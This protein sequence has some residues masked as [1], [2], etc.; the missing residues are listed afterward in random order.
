MKKSKKYTLY[1]WILLGLWFLIAF[2]MMYYLKKEEIDGEIYFIILMGI[3]IVLL[4]PSYYFEKKAKKFAKE[5][6]EIQVAKE[7]EEAKKQLFERAQIN[8]INNLMYELYSG[9][10]PIINELLEKYDLEMEYLY[11]EE[12]QEDWFYIESRE[13]KK[14]ASEYYVFELSG[15]G[16]I[17]SDHHDGIDISSKSHEE[18]VEIIANDIKEFF[19]D[20]E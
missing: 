16:K 6:L 18:M 19:S 20:G 8:N 13:F 2:P 7:K 9:N 14:K 11:D 3:S 10:E 5:E 1:Q 12:S 15:E 4:A 17:S